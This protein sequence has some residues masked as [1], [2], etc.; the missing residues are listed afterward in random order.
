MRATSAVDASGPAGAVHPLARDFL[1][2]VA[3]GSRTYAE[4]MEAWQTSCP[5]LSI[6]EDALDDGLVASV[7]SDGDAA[8]QVIVSLTARGRVVLAGYN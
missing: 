3:E 8:G 4:V 2:W 7:R 1:A 6:W 5:R